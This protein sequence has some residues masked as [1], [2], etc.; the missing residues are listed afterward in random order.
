MDY[1]VSTANIW[2]PINRIWDNKFCT[3]QNGKAYCTEVYGTKQ[4]ENNSSA[5]HPAPFFHAQLNDTPQPDLEWQWNSMAN[6]F[7]LFDTGAAATCINVRSF[8]RAFPQKLSKRSSVP[9]RG[10][11]MN[12]VGIYKRPLSSHQINVIEDLN[13]NIIC[14][15]FMHRHEHSYHDK[16][17][18][19][20]CWVRIKKPHCL[21]YLH[22][23]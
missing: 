9:S 4:A 8:K 10:G 18:V 1:C 19:Q 13:D 15:A 5:Q 22:H 3:D 20:A 6:L 14:T 23:R 11:K 16:G 17:N 7:W 21:C 12:S 2:V